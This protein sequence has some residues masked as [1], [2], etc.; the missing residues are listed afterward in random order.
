MFPDDHNATG[1][2]LPY[3]AIP[4]PAPK[5]EVTM[6]VCNETHDVYKSEQPLIHRFHKCKG[7]KDSIERDMGYGL[8]ATRASIC[9]Q[10]GVGGPLS[11]L[12]IEM[13]FPTFVAHDHT[14][15]SIR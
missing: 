15:A 11:V 12:V 14:H 7:R 8:H 4:R 1:V 2:R 13:W 3:L 6:H 5:P 9:C 10:I